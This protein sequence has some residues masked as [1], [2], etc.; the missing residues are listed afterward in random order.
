MPC[1][2]V[3]FAICYLPFAI[4][5]AFAFCVLRFTIY[6]LRRPWSVL[7]SRGLHCIANK[8]AESS[9]DPHPACQRQPWPI[10]HSC[11]ES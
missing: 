10:L 2:Q 7:R 1:W 9:L 6:H 3:D 4:C 5:P 11:S 8:E